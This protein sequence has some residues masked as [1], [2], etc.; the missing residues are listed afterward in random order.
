MAH[1]DESKKQG[2]LDVELA[3]DVYRSLLDQSVMGMMITQGMPPRF[4]A[5]NRAFSEMVEYSI[6]ELQA[7]SAEQ[8]VA[9]IHPEDMEAALSVYGTVIDGARERAVTAFRFKRQDG[10]LRWLE[11][12]GSAVRYE[13][14]SAVM[15]LCADITERRQAEAALRDSEQQY[16]LLAENASD[17]IWTMDLE[18]NATYVSPSEARLRGYPMAEVR[19]HRFDQRMTPE[20]LERASTGM[21]SAM[22]AEQAG[23]AAFPVTGEMDL[24][25]ADG[26]VLPTETTV[27]LLRDGEGRPTGFLGVTRDISRR[28]RAEEE[29]LAL[30]TQV[31]HSQ[32]L[33]SLG[34]LVGGVAHDFNNL[35]HGLVTNMS[36]VRQ[37]L[38]ESSPAVARLDDMDTATRQ[39][40]D[41]CR[42]ML[43]YAGKGRLLAEPVDLDEVV[44]EMSGLLAATLPGKGRLVQKLDGG[45]PTLLAD[46]SQLRQV[47][48]NLVTNGAEALGEH[49]GVVSLSTGSQRCE[50]EYLRRAMLGDAASPGMFVFIE[51]E[52]DG[53]GMDAD[54]AA[55]M[56]E[57]F[58]STKFAGRGLGLAAV[59]GIVRAHRGAVTVDSEAGQGS[60]IRVVLPV[61]ARVARPAVADAPK[62]PEMDG[63]GR[64]LLVVDD[65]R[66][67]REG[68]ELVLAQRGFEVI[69]ASG[70]NAA[71]EVVQE[72]GEELAV[73]LLDLTMPDMDGVETFQRLRKLRE[74]L[75]VV[76]CSG[77][78]MDE[79]V[80]RFGGD[81]EHLAG[82]LH[83]PYDPLTLLAQLHD[84]L[85]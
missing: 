53:A 38:S 21:A 14:Q 67:S 50:P 36:L 42:Q 20:S 82:F 66:L 74:D 5:V 28:K 12:S 57:P 49:G 68:L 77:Y 33:D 70:G 17:I 31:Q 64:L 48:M 60:R 51:V 75:P 81:Q 9:L 65:D 23:H 34:L 69:T 40:A 6:S 8:V 2:Q 43:A 84:I 59:S 44:T 16:R 13:G 7:M 52:D 62:V 27:S 41:L 54:T 78:G 30:E 32:K 61:L 1:R 22:K 80:E 4:V 47:V 55:H 26:S 35:L 72:R 37:E 39:A 24:M 18:L 58:Y 85:D 11:A 56:F 79:A 15:A 29:R 10:E 19:T 25:C 76:L 3:Q 73:V 46:V 71:L 45:L 83:K 63:A